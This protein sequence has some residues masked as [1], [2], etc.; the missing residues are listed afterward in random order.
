MKFFRKIIF[1]THLVS[2]LT[3]GIVIMIMSVTGVLLTF[4][5]QILNFAD[6]DARIVQSP[7]AEVQRLG[8]QE[9]LANVGQTKPNVR[10]SAITIQSD[11]SVSAIV[12]LGRDGT[13][14]VNQYTGELAGESSKPA[15][16]FFR[17]IEDWHR[18]FGVSNENRA[19]GRALTGA[20]NLL[21]FV[22]AVTGIYIWFPRKFSRKN[23]KSVMIFRSDLRGKS[24]NFNWHN[25]IGFWSSAILIVLTLTAIVM[26]YSWANNL[27][28]TLTG[29][30]PPP[31]QPAPQP[32]NR[33][34]EQKFELPANLNLLWANAEQQVPVW[35][36]ITM[37][38]PTQPDAPAVFVFDDNS[39]WNQMAR[40][41]L[42]LNAQTG[43]V[44]KW[45][46][47]QNLNA[48]RKLRTWARFAHTG[49]SF[50]IIGQIIAG[51]A[52]LG[53]CFLV[54]TGF[55]LAFRRFRG[56]LN[57]RKFKEASVSENI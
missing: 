35:N 17:V 48:G 26:S 47:Y 32:Q 46:P 40:S 24:R 45:E 43:E 41:N 19:V 36:S 20:S 25:V 38:L 56:W 5:P 30:D 55:S 1:W 9:L 13:I 31:N 12:N 53:G 23:F 11:K 22:L 6:R 14:Y 4:E 15:R 34:N 27:L 10:P 3:A 52:T 37:R 50:G 8:V 39:S 7:N 33:P 51:L 49:E 18:W 42:T 16:E 29:N 57:R 44:I 2:G 21:F 28:Y 54:W